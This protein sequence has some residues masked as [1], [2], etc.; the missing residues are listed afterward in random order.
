MSYKSNGINQNGGGVLRTI[1][2]VLLTGI[3]W[4][5]LSF[6]AFAPGYLYAQQNLRNFIETA[7]S[8][9]AT[10]IPPLIGLSLLTFFYGVIQFLRASSTNPAAAVKGRSILIWG[11]F[12]LFVIVS[13]WGIIRVV[14]TTFGL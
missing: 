12:V 6:L 4:V 13:V 2:L 5:G 7:Q 11:I 10:A 9:V 1:G 3:V 8:L 14:R